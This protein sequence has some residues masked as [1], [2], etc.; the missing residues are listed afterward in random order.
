MLGS[1]L[2]TV[3]RG[4]LERETKLSIIRLW[5]HSIG[6]SFLHKSLERIRAAYSREWLQ[7]DGSSAAQSLANLFLEY[8]ADVFSDEELFA[9]IPRVEKENDDSNDQQRIDQESQ[10][11]RVRQQADI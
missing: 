9:D 10:E 7:G 4:V 11:V 8:V 6:K 1:N 2:Q 3:E 5:E